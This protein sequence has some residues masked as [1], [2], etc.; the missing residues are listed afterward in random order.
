VD[1]SAAESGNSK[2]CTSGSAATTNAGDL[3]FAANTVATSTTKAGA[4]FTNRMITS[5]DSDIVED[6]TVTVTGNYSATA[7]LNQ[8]GKWIMQL[9]AFRAAQ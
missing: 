4:G 3:L 7:P 6:R 1:V 2:S 8:S 9:V 5:P